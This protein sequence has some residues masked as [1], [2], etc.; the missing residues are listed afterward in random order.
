MKRGS[1][2]L[3]LLPLLFILAGC[4]TRGMEADRVTGKVDVFGVQMGAATDYR[5]LNGVEAT[6]EP[7]LHGYERSFDALDI[8]IGYGFGK[9]IRKIFTRNPSTGIFGIRPGMTFEE[10]R[11]LAAA[12][13]FSQQ[14]SP[15]IYRAGSYDL[16]FLLEEEK[17]LGLV[18]ERRD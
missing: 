1:A 14:T 17:V 9:R 3:I 7:C 18:L 2:I 4:M 10:G 12:A 15:H 11:R 8:A 5:S 13:G 16:K 6:E